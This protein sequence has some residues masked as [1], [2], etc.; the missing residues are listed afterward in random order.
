MLVPPITEDHHHQEQTP[1][2]C[3]QSEPRTPPS[4]HIPD[5][6]INLFTLLFTFYILINVID[7]KM[8][9]PPACSATVKEHIPAYGSSCSYGSVLQ[10]QA[11]GNHPNIADVPA[12]IADFH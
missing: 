10:G 5:E 7:V 2:H 3:S 6:G 12:A 4:K 11:S 1:P 8:V 9:S